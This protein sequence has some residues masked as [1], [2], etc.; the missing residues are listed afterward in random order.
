MALST[1]EFSSG[2]ARMNIVRSDFALST[3][4][5]PPFEFF[6]HPLQQKCFPRFELYRLPPKTTELV[7]FEAL[8]RR[9]ASQEV[10]QETSQKS[11]VLE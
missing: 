6:H 11:N 5:K 8:V 10:Y 3:V 7:I 1:Q 4:G 2:P 9:K